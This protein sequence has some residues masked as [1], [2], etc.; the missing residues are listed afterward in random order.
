LFHIQT[1]RPDS[2]R[3]AAPDGGTMSP[4]HIDKPR[5]RLS[6]IFTLL[7][8]ALEAQDRQDRPGEARAFRE[9]AELALK[10]VPARG[11][12]A[13]VEDDLYAA[14]D[15]IAMRHLGLEMPRKAFTN[16]TEQIE[17][18]ATRDRIRQ[19]AGHMQT[20]SDHAY[21]YAGL[22]FGMVFVQLG[23]SR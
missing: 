22:A 6:S 13:P 20:I 21:F 15:R 11:V 4:R 1:R 16:V 10:Q 12:F 19:A 9:F 3:R 7:I 2:A 18:F 8:E 23:A 17:P 5:E 14:I